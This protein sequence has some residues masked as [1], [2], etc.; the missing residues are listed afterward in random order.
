M[1]FWKFCCS[2]PK[3]DLAIAFDLRVKWFL[4]LLLLS[5]FE[6]K[7]LSVNTS[8]SQQTW[9]INT[10]LFLFIFMLRC[11]RIQGLWK[12][13]IPCQ[14]GPWELVNTK[15]SFHHFTFCEIVNVCDGKILCLFS[16]T[17]KYKLFCLYKLQLLYSNVVNLRQVS[18]GL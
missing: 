16:L 18:E 8:A 13:M 5:L 9:G 6:Q 12:D 7:Y 1:F 17:S 2:V 14:K 10:Q 4:H 15:Y 3:V 11:T